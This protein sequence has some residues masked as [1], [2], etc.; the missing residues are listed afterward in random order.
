[1]LHNH[2]WIPLQRINIEFKKKKILEKVFKITSITNIGTPTAA[3]TNRSILKQHVGAVAWSYSVLL[4][5]WRDIRMIGHFPANFLHR[6]IMEC[7]V[8]G[9]CR[10]PHKKNGD[11][12]CYW[13]TTHGKC[14][15]Y[16]IA[17]RDSQFFRCRT[18]NIKGLP[19]TVHSW[20]TS[21]SNDRFRSFNRRYV[22]RYPAMQAITGTKVTSDQGHHASNLYLIVF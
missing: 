6:Q 20:E 3:S 17:T 7:H 5:M 13:R 14:T 22:D 11:S 16:F 15:L 12:F 18:R 8:Q 9:W 21:D 4:G 19:R 10:Q 2:K 1:M